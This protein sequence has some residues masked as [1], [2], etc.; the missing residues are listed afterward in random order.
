MVLRH[1]GR[2]R[3]RRRHLPPRHHPGGRGPWALHLVGEPADRCRARRCDPPRGGPDPADAGRRRRRPARGLARGD[4]V[5]LRAARRPR[6][7][8]RPRRPGPARRWRTDRARHRLRHHPEPRPRRAHHRPA[9]SPGRIAAARAGTLGRPA[10]AGREDGADGPRGPPAAGRRRR[11][12]CLG[13]R[14]CLGHLFG[15]RGHRPHG[16]G[17]RRRSGGGLCSSCRAITASARASPPRRRCCPATGEAPDAPER[18]AHPAG[19]R[20]GRGERLALHRL[21]LFRRRGRTVRCPFGHRRPAAR[22]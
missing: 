3:H 21:G 22:G 6:L 16:D 7:P 20:G 1:P 15:P 18:R 8:P 10:H 4:D 17:P 13:R 12:R 2:R 9:R 19:R 14:G 5:P 11:R